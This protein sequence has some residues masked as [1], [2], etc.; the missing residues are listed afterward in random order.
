MAASLQHADF[1]AQLNTKFRVQVD[2]TNAVDLVLA[3]VSEL[4]TSDR[5]EQF[6]IVFRGPLESFL[7]QGMRPFAHDE[8][9]D[10]PLFLVPVKQDDDGFYYESVFNRLKK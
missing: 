8:M 5:Q 9:G 4:K 2:E 10:F 3:E 7:G 6:A 1:A